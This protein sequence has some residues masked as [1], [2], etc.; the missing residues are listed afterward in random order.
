MICLL[1]GRLI[2]SLDCKDSELVCPKCL[3]ECE[4]ELEDSGWYDGNVHFV[5][6]VVVDY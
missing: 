1:C 4:K 3:N 5:N 6:G 2:N